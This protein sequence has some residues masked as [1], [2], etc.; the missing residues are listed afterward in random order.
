[1]KNI[2]MNILIIVDYFYPSKWG[3]ERVFENLAK[4]LSHNHNVIVLTSRFDNTLPK[5]EKWNLVTIYRVWKTRFLFTL[6]ASFF[7]L[8]LIKNIDLIHTSTYNSAYIAKFLTF[9]KKIP[10]IITCHEILWSKWLKFKWKIKGFFFKKIE[11]FI[12]GFWFFYVFV[13]YHVRNVALAKYNIKNFT[14]IYN[15]VEKI[16]YNLID[17]KQLWFKKDDIIWVFAWRPGWPKWLDF[18][19]ENFYKIKKLNPNFK[20]LLL[21]LEKNNQLKLKKLE[22]YLNK[23]IKILYEVPHEKVYDYLALANIW[24]VPSRSEGFG[25]TAVEFSLLNKTTVLSFVWW[26]P[27]VN[28]WDCHFFKPD[29]ANQFLNAF[30]EIFNW[31]KNAYWYNK[32]L[33]IENMVKN[34]QFIYNKNLKII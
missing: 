30:K 29:D 18:L 17:K 9:F 14:V 31:K 19:L 25:F 11:D 15:W 22:K 5:K 16:S 24:I 6:L 7:W 28:F 23:D 21:L 20:L 3:V 33:S 32:N 1:M 27:E 4:N 12:Y 10:V 8:K 26:I 2:K 13:S 34:Y